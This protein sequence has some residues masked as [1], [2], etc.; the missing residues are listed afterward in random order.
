MQ[1]KDKAQT[2]ARLEPPERLRGGLFGLID[3][4]RNPLATVPKHLYE[5]RY[6]ADRRWGR[7][8]LWIACP[9]LIKSVLLENHTAFEKSPLEKRI[10]RP[11]HGRGIM[12]AEGKDW[13]WQRRSVAPCFRREALL[14]SVDTIAEIGERTVEKWREAG[15]MHPHK[16]DADLSD[17]SFSVLTSTL[18][19]GATSEEKAQLRREI[20]AS[21]SRSSWEIVPGII[22]L[23]EGTWHPARNSMRRAAATRRSLVSGL[24][25]RRTTDDG[26]SMDLLARLRGATDPDTGAAMDDELLNDNLQTFLGA[27]H[28]TVGRALTWILYLLALFPEWQTRL[29]EEISAIAGSS[30]IDRF[31]LDRLPQTECVIKEA[32]RLYPPTPML[33]RIAISPVDV[34]PVRLAE[35]SLVIIPIY[36]LHRHRS[37]WPDPDHFNPARFD[38]ITRSPGNRYVYMP[39]GAGQR[40]CLGGVY[41][42]IELTTLLATFVRG[43]TFE[44]PGELSP[45]LL[46]RMHLRAKDGLILQTL[47]RN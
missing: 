9:D 6:L 46:H 16:V 21:L 39:F 23:P 18:L 33:T 5:D 20:D 47:M 8:V 26:V 25:A 2:P 27:G 1:A 40:S 38:P 24:I 42:M 11:T 30:R 15:S 34:G 41:A 13:H 45:V 43:V 4:V 35:G 28:E 32:L 10:L 12:I 37:H 31:H 14:E 17:A 44:A 29:F 36:A 7:N 22:G 3:L 19:H